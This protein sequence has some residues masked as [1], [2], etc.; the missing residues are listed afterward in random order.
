MEVITPSEKLYVRL[1]GKDRMKFQKGEINDCCKQPENLF[2]VHKEESEVN[3]SRDKLK[4]WRCR[5][6]GRNHYVL[7]AEPGKFGLIMK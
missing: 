4:V 3:P 5:T 7:H 2:L 6:C 1:V